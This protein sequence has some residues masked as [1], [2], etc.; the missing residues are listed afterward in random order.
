MYQDKRFVK[1]NEGE[2]CREVVAIH[3]FYDPS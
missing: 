2:D 1:V 3:S